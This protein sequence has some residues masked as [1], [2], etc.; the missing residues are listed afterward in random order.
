MVTEISILAV[1]YRGTFFF[2][3][4]PLQKKV[5][6]EIEKQKDEMKKQQEKVKALMDRIAAEIQRSSCSGW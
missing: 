5:S 4:S 1:Y 6:D 3:V 2:V